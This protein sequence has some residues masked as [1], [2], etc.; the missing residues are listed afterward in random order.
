MRTGFY[1]SWTYVAALLGTGLTL[2]TQATA[3]E[4][5]IDDDGYNRTYDDPN[6]SFK[7]RMKESREV[8]VVTVDNS[9]GGLFLGINANLGPVYDA[10]PTS[11]SGMGYGFGV[12]PGY[13]IQ[14]DSWGRFEVSLLGSYQ[15]FSWKG[16]K[17]TDSTMTPMVFMPRV[18]YGF[19]MG[20]NLYGVLR[21]GL[22]MA[23]GQ[24]SN[25]YNGETFK[26]DSKSGMAFS[27]DYDVVYGTTFVQFT[28]GLGVT[29]YK[30]SFSKL[31]QADFDSNLNL[32][33]IN[34]HGGVRL[35][36]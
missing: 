21:V 11:S 17:N 14:N 31:G 36:F 23:T 24:V 12:E 9:K 25:K 30:Y 28:G 18:G 32:N 15:S 2:A 1:R 20:N 35:A 27:T 7:T 19:G 29:H 33:H 5:V 16:G 13:A 4:E 22:G 8:P 34:V 6:K 3:K 26:T 10:E